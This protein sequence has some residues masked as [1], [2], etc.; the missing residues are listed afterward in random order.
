ME[1]I[2][3]GLG[4]IKTSEYKLIANNFEIVIHQKYSQDEDIFYYGNIYYQGD[5]GR[6]RLERFEFDEVE[7]LEDAKRRGKMALQ[8]TIESVLNDAK[9]ALKIITR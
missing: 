2:K 4:F 3:G 1:W 8:E 7:D 6:V 5:D 9:S